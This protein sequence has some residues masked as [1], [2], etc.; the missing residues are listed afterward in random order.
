MRGGHLRSSAPEAALAR[1]WANGGAGVLRWQ[2][3]GQVHG[4][5]SC[6]GALIGLFEGEGEEVLGDAAAGGGGRSLEG[7]DFLGTQLFAQ[8]EYHAGT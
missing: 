1:N 2:N 4:W 3:G 7:L 8:V 5:G 6:C